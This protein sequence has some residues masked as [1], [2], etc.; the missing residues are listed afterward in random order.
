M[1]DLRGKGEE[2]FFFR[3]GSASRA[4]KGTLLVVDDDPYVL[5]SI[6]QLFLK[7][8][9]RVIACQSPAE[10]IENLDMHRVDA[11]LSDI[12]MPGL[13][14]TELLETIRVKSPVPVILMTAH[15]DLDATMTSIKE[16]AFD[17]VVKPCRSLQLVHTVEKALNYQNLVRIGRE[18]KRKLEETVA[19]RTRELGD[20]LRMVQ[21]LSTEIVRRLTAV[22]E[23]RDTESAAHNTR[24]GLYSREIAG[25]LGMEPGFVETLAFAGSMHD[26]GKIGIPDSILLKRGRLEKDEFETIKS[27]TLMGGDILAGSSCAKLK[28]SASVA[29]TH[30][31]KWDGSGYPRGLKGAEIPIEG[32]IVMICDQYDALRSKRPYKR[33]LGHAEV[34]DIIVRGNGRTMPCHFDPQIL[35]AF[36]HVNSVFESIFKNFVRGN[37]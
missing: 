11:V 29:L 23:F 21:D 26:I 37:S 16:G 36:I 20:A 35:D 33:G 10:A 8:G 3:E 25:A 6:K 30:H 18:Y 13:A 24:I 7:N 28:I 34:M 19:Q 22:A 31:E 27:H 4:A 2:G 9:Y 5:S 12:K 14:G 32:R 15:A 17:F 1:E